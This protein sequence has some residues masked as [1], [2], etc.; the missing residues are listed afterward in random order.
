MRGR[1]EASDPGAW[2]SPRAVVLEAGRHG[3]Q[4]EE[5]GSGGLGPQAVG[6]QAKHGA[7]AAPGLALLG[8]PGLQALGVLET[9]R[10]A[11]HIGGGS[12]AWS[13]GPG[14]L[15]VTSIWDLPSPCYIPL[16][17]CP[18]LLWAARGGSA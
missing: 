17:S 8:R 15:S 9:S 7:H 2:Q 3:T 14:A 5:R 13:R 1:C 18:G 10:P 12:A 6:V 16:G 4:G 11:W